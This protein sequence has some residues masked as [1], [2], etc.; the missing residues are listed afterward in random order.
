VSAPQVQRVWLCL[1]ALSVR[2]LMRCLCSSCLWHLL[3][4]GAAAQQPS[5][6]PSP[7]EATCS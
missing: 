3:C 2:L 7:K 5:G 6:T 4:D 1:A